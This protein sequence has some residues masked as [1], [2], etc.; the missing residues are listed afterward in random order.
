MARRY[1]DAEKLQSAI[2]RKR[3]GVAGKENWTAGYN[4]AILR[5]KSMVHSFE[6]EDVKRV[7]HGKWEYVGTAVG[8]EYNCSEC[9]NYIFT[10]KKT[11]DLYP[12]CPYCGAKMDAKIE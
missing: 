11:D 9:G 6:G 4:D 8:V 2:E 1:I 3:G 5:I 7:K 12:Y 10:D